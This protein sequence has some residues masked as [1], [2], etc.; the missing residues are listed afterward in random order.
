MKDNG[1]TI[2]VESEEKRIKQLQDNVLR[3]GI[4]SVKIIQGDVRSLDN[5]GQFDKILLDAPCSSIGVIRRNLDIKY[6]HSEK[7]LRRFKENQIDILNA[8]SRV[9][10]TGGIMVYSV[11]STEP[12]EGEEVVNEFLHNNPNFSIIKGDYDFLSHFESLGKDGYLF[13]RT[14]P[15]RHVMDGF[16]AVRLKKN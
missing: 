6:R 1:E 15:H 8:V 10:K 3:L 16:F 12:E 5:I 2:A 14:F 4:K 9:L 7:D 11:C 13:Y